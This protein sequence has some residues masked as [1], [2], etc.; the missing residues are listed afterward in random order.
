MSGS[1]AWVGQ[2]M[3][4]ACPQARLRL[5][6]AMMDWRGAALHGP[7]AAKAMPYARCLDELDHTRSQ[8][9]ASRAG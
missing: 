6:G 8:Q 7:R 5:P 3:Q 9:S 1:L 2:G 4:G